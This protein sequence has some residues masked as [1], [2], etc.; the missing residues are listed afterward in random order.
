[1]PV[2][3]DIVRVTLYDPNGK[4]PKSRRAVVVTKTEEIEDEVVV[5]A[6]S[7]KFDPKGLPDDYVQVPWHRDGHAWTSLTEPS[8]VKCKW[9]D[10]VKC[11]DLTVAGH[12]PGK[13]LLRV[14]QTIANLN[15]T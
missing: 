14:V 11:S 10:V 7:T 3:G 1:M 4:N 8:V 2:Q 6:I 9:L 5:A 12:L 13:Y 15:A